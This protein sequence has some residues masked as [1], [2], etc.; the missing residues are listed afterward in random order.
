MNSDLLQSFGRMFPDSTLPSLVALVSQEAPLSPSSLSWPASGIL[1]RGAY[2]T[3]NTSD[4]PSDESAFSE[5]SL[6][7]I[8]EADP[9]RKFLLSPRACAG[10]LR[11]AERLGKTLP[12]HLE[13]SLR[14]VAG[15]QASTAGPEDLTP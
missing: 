2:L 5:C 12:V 9:P 6:R 7:A 4:W 11:R 8:L 13:A 1:E 3:L 15:A 10:I 14:A